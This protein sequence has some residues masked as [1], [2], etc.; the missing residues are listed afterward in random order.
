MNLRNVKENVKDSNSLFFFSRSLSRLMASFKFTLSFC[1]LNPEPSIIGERK[2]SRVF[3][4]F[5]I[6][7]TLKYDH[8]SSLNILTHFEMLSIRHIKIRNVAVFRVDR[9][10]FPGLSLFKIHNETKI[11]FDY[12]GRSSLGNEVCKTSTPTLGKKVWSCVR[13]QTKVAQKRVY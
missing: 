11:N 6:V 5:Q 4:C 3:S 1:L 13:A 2:K 10:Q 12:Y 7:Q 9:H 8:G